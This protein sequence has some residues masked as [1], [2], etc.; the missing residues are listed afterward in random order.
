M[1][2]SIKGQIG[3]MTAIPLVGACLLGALSIYEISVERHHREVMVPMTRIATEAANFAHELQKERGKS[4][5][6]IANDYATG[7]VDAVTEQ[8]ALSDEVTQTFLKSL[9]ASGE[10]SKTIQKDFKI[11]A[12]DIA[13]ISSLRANIDSKSAKIP[14][15]IKGYTHIVEDTIKLIGHI[16]EASPSESVTAELFVYLMLVEAKE[17]G[18][19][20]R[21]IGAAMLDETSRG[22]FNFN[23]Y[24]AYMGKLGQENA[25]FATIRTIG[26]EDQIALI[27]QVVSGPAVDKVADIRQVLERISDTKDSKGIAGAEWFAIATERLNLIKQVTDQFAVRAVDA[28]NAE[29]ANYTRQM[30]MIVGF[31]AAVLLISAAIALYQ[32]TSIARAMVGVANTV[33]RLSRNEQVDD[34]PMTGRPDEIGD[35]A[36]AS[37]VF[38]DSL[39]ER[40][41]LQEA[42][43]KD[44][45]ARRERQ[46]RID[47]IVNRFRAQSGEIQATVHGNMQTLQG[48]AQTLIGIAENT[49][50]QASVAAGASEEASSNVQ[51]VAAASEEMAASI[52]EIGRQ[53]GETTRVV[54]DTTAIARETNEKIAGLAS[55]AERIGDV[56]NLIQDIA[57]QTNLLALNATIEAARAG[58]MG[59][60]F[61][62]VA[63]EVKELAN[64]TSKATGE[65]ASQISSIQGATEESVNAIR[66]ISEQIEEVNSYTSGISAAVEQQGGATS[67]ITR[68]VQQA[69][70]GTQ[71]VA[72]NVAAV[73]S[74]TD[75]TN[76]SAEA[77][78]QAASEVLQQTDRLNMVVEDFLRD[79]A[80]A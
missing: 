32:T 18:G 77:A 30:Y 23:R 40:Q 67:E 44:D 59:K 65:I 33:N 79:V 55:A 52:G 3:L 28:V 51:T 29:I 60:G 63:A 68:N 43:A 58:D 36:R 9:N 76:R 49:A 13:G 8:R 80:A 7:R 6:M 24:K 37:E 27:D 42:Q 22:E 66:R 20:E 62:V 11:L 74:A 61:A 14:D 25:F 70:M 5:G 10:V 38:R 39:A 64:Q 31:V 56:V 34:I 12:E 46:V 57:E 45:E 2:K 15:V 72:E 41:R 35:I 78:N 50:N 26:K 21:A 69:A 48:T 19:L 53:V 4:V 73:T 1:F 71:S 54:A 17:A 16:T 75:E 47:E